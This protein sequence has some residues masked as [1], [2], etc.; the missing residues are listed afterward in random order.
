MNEQV[1]KSNK[2]YNISLLSFIALIFVILGHSGCIYAGIWDY[3]IFNNSSKIIKYITQ[4]I[5]SFHMPLYMFISGYLY[6]YNKVILGK[7][8]SFK[9]FIKNKA[10]RLLIPYVITGIF[11]MIPIQMIFKIY[12]D[13]YSFLYRVINEI[14][15]ERRPAH[16]WF[17]LALFNIFIIFYFIESI[18]NKR[19][20]MLNFVILSLIGVASCK[21]PSVYQI[22]SSFRY[23]VYFYMG[24]VFY[25]NINSIK[26]NIQVKTYLFLFHFLLFNIQYF[27][28]SNIDI[29]TIYFKTFKFL[30]NQV[31]S[32]LG[33]AYM[34]M[35]IYNLCQDN[36]MIKKVMQNKIFKLIYQNKFY[37]YLVHQPIMLSILVRIKSINI[38]P[39]TVFI[40]LFWSTFFISLLL[41]ACIT[42]VKNNLLKFS[43]KKTYANR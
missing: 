25:Q 4:Y 21:F 43:K 13:N 7:Y 5:Y 15:L 29:N 41:S 10:K 19:C 37:M 39:I 23:L 3:K 42:K 35:C 26:N 2:L 32:M 20:T 8:G 16:L 27:V 33:V 28:L 30:F 17:L 22:G 1:S 6:Y 34:F 40:L 36:K 12:T 14:L 11:F 38:K 31:V 9:E 18:L 24:Y